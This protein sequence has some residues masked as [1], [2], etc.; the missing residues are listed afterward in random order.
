MWSA[1]HRRPLPWLSSAAVA[2]AADPSP[3]ACAYVAGWLAGRRPVRMPPASTAVQSLL[4]LLQE[5]RN[6]YLSE[7]AAFLRCGQAGP[8]LA[9]PP[10]GAPTEDEELAEFTLAHQIKQR[11]LARRAE[12]LARFLRLSAAAG[13]GGGFAGASLSPAT[14]QGSTPRDDVPL[15]AGRA[16]SSKLPAAAAAEGMRL[17]H[18]SAEEAEGSSRAARKLGFGAQQSPGVP[19]SLTARAVRLDH[20]RCRNV[21]RLAHLLHLPVV[22]DPCAQYHKLCFL[23]L[24]MALRHSWPHPPIH[25]A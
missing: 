7:E 2:V 8:S 22:H 3:G 11:L 23:S 24:G 20:T 5:V 1:E 9:A 4:N 10:R 13:S 12:R 25:C 15:S 18:D 19:G 17:S 6:D 21:Q 14:S 16:A